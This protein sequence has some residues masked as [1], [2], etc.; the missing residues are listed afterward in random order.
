MA[1]NIVA[2]LS[3]DEVYH[4]LLGFFTIESNIKVKHCIEPSVI[5]TTTKFPATLCDIRMEIRPENGKTRIEFNF[6]FTKSYVLGCVFFGLG[7]AIT[8]FFFGIEGIETM[9]IIS[10]VA[11]AIGIPRSLS[12]TKKSF[13]ERVTNLLKEKEHS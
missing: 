4:F 2:N 3:V 6:D 11:L 10:T 7:L 9:V 1:E 13:I 12:K 8:G 5:N